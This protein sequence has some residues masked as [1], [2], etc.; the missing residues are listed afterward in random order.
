VT[1]RETA[2]AAPSLP[3]L[4]LSVIG[5]FL[6]AGKTTLVNRW[7]HEAGGS[8]LAVLVND[9]GAV[10]VDAELIASVAG[11]MIALTNGCVCCQIGDDF[12]AALMRV[13]EMRERFDAVVVEA[14]GVSDPTRIA[15]Y[16]RA[17]PE[18]ALDG[19][20]VLVDASAF[21]AQ[22]ADP[23]LADTLQRQ[24]ASADLI[25]LNK[26]DIATPPQLAAAHERLA[27]WAAGTACIE[28]AHA[29]LPLALMSG[30]ALPSAPLSGSTL[31]T[32][33]SGPNEHGPATAHDPAALFESWHCHP[34]HRFDAAALR[35]WLRAVPDSVLR[36]K[37]IV[38]TD[39]H[40][41]S[42]L[43]FAG[44]RGSLRKAADAPADGAALVA[45][46]LRGKLPHAALDAAFGTPQS[47]LARPD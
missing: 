5:G 25:V 47:G 24:V 19:V 26:A 45:I 34:G 29:V 32:F 22:A 31:Q 44:R 8:R 41:W 12:A 20:I 13:L 30:P 18:L 10:N 16:G 17:V 46:G 6:G 15:G 23:L 43:Q 9:F 3:P 1:T 7:L 42:E 39:A 11:D 28:T 4:P 27:R 33:D 36:L 21:D 35:A 2:A 40:G 14:S 38:Q 37:G